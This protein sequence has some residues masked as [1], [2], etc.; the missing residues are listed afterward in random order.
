[1]TSAPASLTAPIASA[2]ALAEAI[3][4]GAYHPFTGPIDF[5]DGTPWL[6]EGETPDD[7]VL[8]GLS[9]YVEGLTGD[10]PN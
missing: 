6:A 10:I 2:T 1:L 3:A 5:Q 7:G 8:A 9:A 4:S